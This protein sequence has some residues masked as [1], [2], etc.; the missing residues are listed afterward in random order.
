MTD[1]T[2][3]LTVVLDNIYRTDDAEA[4][5]SAIGMVK[6]VASV[7]ANVADIETH[8]AYDRARRDLGEKLWAIL[9]PP[10]KA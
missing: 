8:T 4:I 6:G 1:R 7:T 10:K 2:V 3:V 9:Y 5:I